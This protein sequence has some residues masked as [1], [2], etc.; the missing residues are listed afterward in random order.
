MAGAKPITL[1]GKPL[2]GGT[3][4]VICTPLVAEAA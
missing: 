4:P 3:M 2:A 1:H